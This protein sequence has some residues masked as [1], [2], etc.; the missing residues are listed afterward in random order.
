MAVKKKDFSQV[1]E[2]LKEM[3]QDPTLQKN[4]KDKIEIIFQIIEEDE[5]S[6]IKVDK[7]MHELDELSD[8]A[9]LQAYTRTQ[10][11]NLVS[12]LENV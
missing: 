12:L 9:N 6:R 2:A 4:V 7:I 11:W 10:I 1:I 3:D 5:D 8:N